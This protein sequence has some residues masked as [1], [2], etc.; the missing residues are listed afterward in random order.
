MVSESTSSSEVILF[1]SL[2]LPLPPTSKPPLSVL[3][4][5]GRGEEEE[6]EAE[7]AEA[8]L[9]FLFSAFRKENEIKYYF[10]NKASF[11]YCPKK[12]TKN[13]MDTCTN[14]KII[15]CKLKVHIVE[16]NRFLSRVFKSLCSLSFLE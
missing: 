9:V 3:V 7:E 8:A 6:K 5:V 16:I 14:V 13:I 15:F 4:A 1:S 12:H 11:K 10:L 2:P